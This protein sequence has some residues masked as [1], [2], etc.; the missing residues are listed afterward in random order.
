MANV[1]LGTQSGSIRSTVLLCVGLIALVLVLFVIKVLR[2]VSLDEEA[3]RELGVVLLPVPR[4]V[5][6]EGLT[7]ITEQP[8]T[9]DS[10]KGRWSFVFFGFTHCPDICPTTMAE[11]GKA[12]RELAEKSPNIAKQMQ[13]V[14]VTVDP[15]RDDPE[16]LERYVR[17]FSASFTGMTGTRESLANFATQVNVAFGKIPDGNGGYTVDHTGNIVIINPQGHYRGF[18]KM[19]QSAHTIRETTTSLWER[20]PEG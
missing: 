14:L 10:F 1:S 2:P 13:G 19:P 12:Y 17:T 20:Y 8:V 4:E 15:E 11:M 7:D 9:V 3:L 6:I 5:L 18:I 16:T